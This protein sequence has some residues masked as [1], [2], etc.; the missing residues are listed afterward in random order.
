MPSS[1]PTATSLPSVESLRC[2]FSAARQLNFRRAASEVGLTPTAF[3]ERIRGLERELGATLFLRTTRRVLLTAEGRAL[4]PAAERALASV[5][6]CLRAIDHPSALTLRVRLGT[7]FEL[8]LSWLV[9]AVIELERRRPS[10]LVDLYFGSGPDIL[11]RLER[12][13]LD[14][15]ITSAPV[16]RDSWHVEVLHPESYTFVA[17]PRLL[18][19]LPLK[20]PGD[21][22]RHTLLD[23]DESLPL[24]RYLL[25]AVPALEFESV[26]LCGAGAAVRRRALAADGVAVLPSYMLAADLR[27]RRLVRLFPRVTLLSDSFRL[28]YPR[29][30]PQGEALQELA[31]FLRKRPLS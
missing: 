1:G 20:N 21:A 30:T 22:R 7:R 9:P 4:M 6:D 11:Q 14:A 27:A 23:V 19:D 16:A 10:L 5:R 13:A 24:A 29:S 17:A 12:G 25:S 15:A 2:F 18:E 3:S 28:V 31:A 26:R 8:G